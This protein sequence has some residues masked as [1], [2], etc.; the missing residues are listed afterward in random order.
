LTEDVFLPQ[1]K[2]AKSK[3]KTE[4]SLTSRDFISLQNLVTFW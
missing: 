3:E 4:I 1:K 2:D